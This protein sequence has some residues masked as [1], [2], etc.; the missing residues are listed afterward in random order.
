MPLCYTTW[1]G[2]PFLIYTLRSKVSPRFHQLSKTK[3]GL[4]ALLRLPELGGQ[5]GWGEALVASGKSAA[6]PLRRQTL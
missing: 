2:P 3:L 6:S 1:I 4:S 5:G